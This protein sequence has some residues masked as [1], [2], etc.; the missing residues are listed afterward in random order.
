MLSKIPLL[1][2]GIREMVCLNGMFNKSCFP[3]F[4]VYNLYSFI[5]TFWYFNGKVQLLF[6]SWWTHFETGCC[7]V[8]YSFIFWYFWYTVYLICRST[9]TNRWSLNTFLYLIQPSSKVR[10]AILPTNSS[11]LILF[12]IGKVITG[13]A[14]RLAHTLQTTAWYSLF[15]TQIISK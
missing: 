4:N 7:K 10:A 6:H 3:T 15:K 8:S 1:D 5:F 12:L 9:S 14:S 2:N 13:F 11:V